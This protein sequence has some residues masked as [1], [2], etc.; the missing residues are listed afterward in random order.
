MAENMNQI[1]G[2][3]DATG[4]IKRMSD[5]SGV[6][7]HDPRYL[8]FYV[9]N[10]STTA[11]ITIRMYRYNVDSSGSA[12]TISTWY[13]S[14]DNSTWKS[15]SPYTNITIPANGI[16]YLRANVSRWGNG[17]N[18]YYCNCMYMSGPANIGGN[19]GSLL[20]NTNIKPVYTSSDGSKGQ[21][22][23]NAMF[24]Y[25]NS[26]TYSR[27]RN[28]YN[29][30]NLVIPKIY[31]LSNDYVATTLFTGQSHVSAQGP[32]CY[33]LPETGF[34]TNVTSIKYMSDT[35]TIPT[36]NVGMASSGTYYCKGGTTYSG[37]NSG[38]TKVSLPTWYN[39]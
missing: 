32:I 7:W 12:P 29:I 8:P 34:A 11:S 35:T 13:Y 23:F 38:W 9:Q 6:V 39:V 1:I 24:R 3:K 15:Q 17:T 31:S 10:R 28:I 27:S 25:N 37:G 20:Y 22:P 18:R 26:S 30:Y 33:S 2:V 19:L 4:G 21:Y 16:C 14:F 5:S 36:F